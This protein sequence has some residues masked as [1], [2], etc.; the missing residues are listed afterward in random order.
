M[1]PSVSTHEVASNTGAPQTSVWRELRRNGL[2]CY[3]IH[4]CQKLYPGDPERRLAYCNWLMNRNEFPQ[5]LSTVIWTDE[6][7]FTNC[8]MFNR[9]NEHI[10]SLNNPREFRAVRPQVR[11]SLNVWAGI[12]GDQILGPHFFNGT[13]NGETYLEFL[14]GA[15]EDYFDNLPLVNLNQYWFQHDGAPPHNTRA[16]CEYLNERFPDRWI[17]NN[18]PVRWPARSPDLTVLDTFLWGTLKNRVYG[19]QEFDNVEDLR[20]SIIEQCRSIRRRDIVR[21]VENLGRR[22]RLCIQEEGRNFEQLL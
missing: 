5:F 11:F 15:F 3:K 12:C 2:K 16:V 4:I 17:G 10:W 18:G 20:R 8:G 9:N 13:L 7:T 6:S 19:Q 22:T 1:N 14:R 21:A